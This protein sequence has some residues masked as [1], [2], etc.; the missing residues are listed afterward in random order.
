MDRK[1][2]DRRADGDRRQQDGERRPYNGD[3]NQNNGDRN[4]NNGERRNFDNRR[5]ND[6]VASKKEILGDDFRKPNRNNDYQV[7]RPR[8]ERE[9]YSKIVVTLET[10]IPEGPKKG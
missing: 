5:N 4:Q 1:N 2:N 6:G 3:R 8:V 7:R 9:D 10:E